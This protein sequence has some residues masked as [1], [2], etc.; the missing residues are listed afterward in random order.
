M[1]PTPTEDSQ[2]KKTN[3]SVSYSPNSSNNSSNNSN[4]PKRQR[5]RSK[6]SSSNSKTPSSEASNR[7]GKHQLNERLRSVLYDDVGLPLVCK[8]DDKDPKEVL[9]DVLD[10]SG[11]PSNTSQPI[12]QSNDDRWDGILKDSVNK[13]R[14]AGKSRREPQL[15]NILKEK[16]NECD[17][18]LAQ[19]KLLEKK[20]RWNA[21]TEVTVW[22][23]QMEG[24]IDLILEKHDLML[25]K[26]VTQKTTEGMQKTMQDTQNKT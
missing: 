8:F 2:A 6:R 13:W 9:K 16:I 15:C 5:Q 20:F 24:R 1:E 18:K 19:E 7:G 4:V 3:R 12:D 26:H 17:D 22:Q 21:R 10:G 23:G 25:E 11:T 14:K